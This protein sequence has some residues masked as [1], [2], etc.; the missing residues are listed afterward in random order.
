MGGILMRKELLVTPEIERPLLYAQRKQIRDLSVIIDR[1][2]PERAAVRTSGRFLVEWCNPLAIKA[3]GRKM[4][5]HLH[6]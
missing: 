4:R 6:N 3:P 5:G 2:S 1:F